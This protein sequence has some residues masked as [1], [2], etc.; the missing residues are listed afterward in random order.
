MC[1]SFYGGNIHVSLYT[2]H[3]MDMK[4]VDQLPL[5]ST[6]TVSTMTQTE[7]LSKCV[8][9]CPLWTTFDLVEELHWRQPNSI[10]SLKELI[11]TLQ[12]NCSTIFFMSHVCCCASAITDANDKYPC[13]WRQMWIFS[14]H[15]LPPRSGVSHSNYF[16]MFSP[17]FTSQLHLQH[18]YSGGKW[19]KLTGMDGG[20]S[21]CF[22]RC[23][24]WIIWGFEP[25]G[26]ISYDY[27]SEL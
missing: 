11:H 21:L 20:S 24:C 23:A 1:I 7:Y 22:G 4:M 5:K 16:Y 17:L 26:L 9:L 18:Q 2:Q 6:N 15:C 3:G 14:Y 25:A 27:H 10:Q 12:I 8:V 19:N 13:C